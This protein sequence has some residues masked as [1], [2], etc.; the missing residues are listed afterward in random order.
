MQFHMISK[1]FSFFPFFLYILDRKSFSFI[2]FSFLLRIRGKN[3][4]LKSFFSTFSSLVHFFCKKKQK[5][6][7]GGFTEIYEQYTIGNELNGV[8]Q[9]ALMSEKFFFLPFFMRIFVFCSAACCESPK[10][11]KHRIMNNCSCFLKRSF[12]EIA[13]RTTR[14]AANSRGFFCCC[15]HI[16]I[17]AFH[18]F[19]SPH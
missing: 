14:I 11:K 19:F 15:R 10:T 16:D 4:K 12:V 13:S 5:E 3:I 17:D 7:V 9:F 18:F 6:T 2:Y 1:D 8:Y